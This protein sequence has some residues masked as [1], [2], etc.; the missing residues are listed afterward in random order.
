LHVRAGTRTLGEAVRA[1]ARSGT[2]LRCLRGGGNVAIAGPDADAD[3]VAA[4]V[5]GALRVHSAGGPLGLPLLCVQDD[6]ADNVIA[7]VL[8]RLATCAPA[9]LPTE[10]LR[11]RALAQIAAL[12]ARGAAV[13]SGGEVPDDVRHRMGWIVPPTVLTA[14]AARDW[15]VTGQP[16]D[17]PTGPVLPV[18]TW[19]S[20][21]D[22]VGA[23]THPRYADG[24]ACTWGLDD[25]ELT[26]TRLPHTVIMRERPPIAALAV[27]SLPA[28]WT[29]GGEPLPGGLRAAQPKRPWT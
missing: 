28:A 10:P 15:P 26:A 12:G 20:P 17:E 22:L 8:A 18:L 1:A 6:A 27:G 25:A 14:G 23:L 7:A 3:Q 9:P 21:S 29:D 4:A 24:I 5:A 2:P 19:H 13:L 11:N 16:L